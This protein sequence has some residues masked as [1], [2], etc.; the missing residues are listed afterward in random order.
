MATL[1]LYATPDRVAWHVDGRPCRDLQ[2][3]LDGVEGPT[4]RVVVTCEGGAVFTVD[5]LHRSPYA[6][7]ALI[8]LALWNAQPVG[9]IEKSK[10]I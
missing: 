2:A 10:K 7:R 3:A 9:K 4:V 6:L 5:G 1:Q 8:P